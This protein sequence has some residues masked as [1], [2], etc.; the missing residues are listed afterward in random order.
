MSS[1]NELIDFSLLLQGTL[2]SC[3]LITSFFLSYVDY[4]GF[5]AFFSG[6]CFT[7]FTGVSYYGV[8]YKPDKIFY[9]AILGAS[10]TLVFVTFLGALFWRDLSFCSVDS[11]YSLTSTPTTASTIAPSSVLKVTSLSE[12]A[13]IRHTS[14]MLESVPSEKLDN[15]ECSQTSAM[16]A[17]S[18]F[19]ALLM[20]AYMYFI[21]VLFRFKDDILGA[22]RNNNRYFAVPNG[23]AANMKDEVDL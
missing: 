13:S 18:I 6:L 3:F 10:V 8:R 1:H 2:S 21:T 23:N 5:V 12:L 11:E 19:S 16:S 22:A 7:S 20:L 17:A 15:M 14:M 9:G 4:V